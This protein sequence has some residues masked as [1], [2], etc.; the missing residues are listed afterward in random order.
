MR[1]TLCCR[2]GTLK[3]FL[4]VFYTPEYLMHWAKLFWGDK[5]RT[6]A[7]PATSSYLRILHSQRILQLFCQ[8]QGRKRVGSQVSQ[9]HTE[10]VLHSLLWVP[11]QRSQRPFL[12][13]CKKQLT[14]A[15]TSLSTP[16]MGIF[17]IIALSTTWHKHLEIRELL[18]SVYCCVAGPKI[19]LG[20]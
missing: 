18:Y 17:I 10:M 8:L 1:L 11:S 12:T 6:W 7:L 14:P 16:H 13:T 19:K 15:S 20:T 4:T 9:G 3:T 5:N 2:W